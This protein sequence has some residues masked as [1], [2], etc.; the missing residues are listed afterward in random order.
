LSIGY[1]RLLQSTDFR[2][3]DV[4]KR[5]G[6]RRPS[7]WIHRQIAG[8]DGS[9]PVSRLLLMSHFDQEPTSTA[10]ISPP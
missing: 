4:A 2:T 3:A 9:M 7:L 8:V 6:L 1:D 5:G 10:L